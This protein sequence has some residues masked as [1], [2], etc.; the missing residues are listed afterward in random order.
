[1]KDLVALVTERTEV[2]EEG[3][4]VIGRTEVKEEVVL[5]DPEMKN[6]AVVE[7]VVAEDVEE[8]VLVVEEEE[9][10]MTDTVE[11]T[12]R[13]CYSHMYLCFLD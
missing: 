13:K 5:V 2:R 12:E 7:V 4:L 10:N 6:A 3:V 11:V 8:E 9:G 1:V